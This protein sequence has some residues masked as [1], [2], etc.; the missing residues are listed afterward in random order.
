M[1]NPNYWL[2]LLWLEIDFS[3]KSALARVLFTAIFVSLV[4]S[5]NAYAKEIV[6]TKPLWRQPIGQGDTSASANHVCNS[7]NLGVIASLAYLGKD[8]GASAETH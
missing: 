8:I 4:S 6:S 2:T 1:P 7:Y 5:T 3:G